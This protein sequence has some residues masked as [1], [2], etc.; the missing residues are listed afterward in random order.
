MLFRSLFASASLRY[1]PSAA[2]VAAGLQRGMDN[3]WSSAT[4][5]ALLK[6][7]QQEE[8]AKVAAGLQSGMSAFWRSPAGQ[9]LLKQRCLGGDDSACATLGGCAPSGYECIAATRV[10]IAAESI[11]W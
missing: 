2:Q 3:F 10:A 5:Q 1:A 6:K 11:Q 4:G 8:A 7:K 9:A